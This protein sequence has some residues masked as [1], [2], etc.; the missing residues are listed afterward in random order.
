[1]GVL[2]KYSFNDLSSSDVELLGRALDKMLLGEAMPLAL[3]MQAQITAQ[4]QSE[5][6][7]RAAAETQPKET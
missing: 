6:E 3:K 7:R 1:M 2:V 5:I 4:D